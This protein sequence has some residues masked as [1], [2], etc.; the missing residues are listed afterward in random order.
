VRRVAEETDVDLQQQQMIDELEK[1]A[2]KLR[3]AIYTRLTPQQKL[4]I[5]R[6]PNRPTFLDV[7]EQITDKFFELHGDRAGYDDQALVGG[8]GSIDGI[9]FML[10]GHQKGRDEQEDIERNFG[11][12]TPSGYR[13]AL[14]LM[15]HAERFGFPIITFVD[16]PGA[17]AGI[18]TE[19][20]GQGEAIAMNLREM[21]GLKVPIICFV[22]GEGGSGGALAIGCADYTFIL[23]N[24][25]YYV[26]SP[27]A[28]AAILWKD[29]TMMDKA[30]SALKITAGDLV[31]LGVMDEIIPEPLGGAH[32]NPSAIGAPIKEALLSTFAEL[33]TLDELDLLTRRR[34]KF[35]RMGVWG[36]TA[37]DDE[38]KI[39][40]PDD[41][42]KA[43]N[44]EEAEAIQWLVPSHSY[45]MSIT[46]LTSPSLPCF[47]NF[48]ES[49]Q[50]LQWAGYGG[51]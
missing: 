15:R 35:R 14:R 38:G 20:L 41:A 27:E 1:R 50:G 48:N 42:V 24:A 43:L 7:V 45:S 31:K 47:G 18:E 26:T 19:T 51:G 37:E 46:P 33:R 25:V 8:I 17:Y 2:A 12:P 28:A 30:T 21:F 34:D 5:A 49:C 9:S 6:H 32:T 10:I 39:L 22:I 4:M 3:V 44:Q 40:D 36:V 23:E 11:M 29:K 13:K 16:T